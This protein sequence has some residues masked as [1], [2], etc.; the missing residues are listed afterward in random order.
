MDSQMTG[1]E[2]LADMRLREFRIHQ[3]FVRSA[4]AMN[5]SAVIELAAAK[6]DAIALLTLLQETTQSRSVAERCAKAK[7]V[8]A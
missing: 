8:L 5:G 2:I 6:A 7:A 1:A 4:N 3:A